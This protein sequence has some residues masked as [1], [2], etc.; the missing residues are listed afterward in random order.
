MVK[1]RVDTFSHLI[2][3][4]A[5]LQSRMMLTGSSS[6]PF[7][8][9]ESALYKTLFTGHSPYAALTGEVQKAGKENG[10]SNRTACRATT[11][12]SKENG[13]SGQKN[14]SPVEGVESSLKAKE[15]S[16]AEAEAS[17]KTN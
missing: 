10:I 2:S 12:E 1:N 15:E 9:I 6:S 14:S 13:S 4:F 5:L 11:K 17:K 16:E 7:S 8:P 3:L